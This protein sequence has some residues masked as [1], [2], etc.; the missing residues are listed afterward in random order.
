M[1]GGSFD[2]GI[3]NWVGFFSF[4]SIL[5]EHPARMLSLLMGSFGVEDEVHTATTPD[6]VEDCDLLNCVHVLG[7]FRT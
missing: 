4:L 2:P 7:F 5:L 6:R 3:G 1:V